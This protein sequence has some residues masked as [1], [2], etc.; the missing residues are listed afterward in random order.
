[1]P[2]V[3]LEEAARFVSNEATRR[4][5]KLVP[6]LPAAL[7]DLC[8]T[9][10]YYIFNVGPWDWDRQLGGKGTKFL[11]KC[12]DGQP[13]GPEPLTFG[14]LDNETVAVDMNKME[15][16]QEEGIEVVNAFLQKGWGS[17]PEASWEH[18][19]LGVTEQWPPSAEDLAAANKRFSAKL[20]ELVHE[21]DK[22]YEQRKHDDISDFHRYAARRRKLAKPWL[23]ENPDLVACAACGSQ[24]MPNIAVCP[25]C[26]ATLNEELAR[27][28][29]PE[30]YRKAS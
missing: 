20:D 30:R 4:N 29:F 24:V 8:H 12:P 23:N 17:R 10:K 15:N 7:A 26:S 28:F 1:M 18:W 13:Y 3:T 16:R 11:A 27:K 14:F 6:K 22:F 2:T 19:G 25:Q 9:P 5:G 21:G